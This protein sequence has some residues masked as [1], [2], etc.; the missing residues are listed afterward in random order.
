[1][2]FVQTFW[3]QSSTFAG[4]ALTEGQRGLTGQSR[5]GRKQSRSSGCFS[6]DF[7]FSILNY[8][9]QTFTFTVPTYVYNMSGF[10]TF[11]ST[12]HTGHVHFELW[13]FSTR[14]HCITIRFFFCWEGAEGVLRRR[15]STGRRPVRKKKTH[16][17][18]SR[19]VL[20]TS[21]GSGLRDLSPH[22]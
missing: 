21:S 6:A 19:F 17:V 15:C 1:M 12:S 5:A 20:D 11:I 22:R 9:F 7:N 13:N 3:V 16:E 4:W 18:G 2:C 8:K 10:P 14:L